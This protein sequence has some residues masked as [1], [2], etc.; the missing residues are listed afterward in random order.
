M[1]LFNLTLSYLIIIKHVEISLSY[2]FNKTIIINNNSNSIKQYLIT[3]TE[4]FHA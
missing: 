2:C 3:R 4:V 1:P